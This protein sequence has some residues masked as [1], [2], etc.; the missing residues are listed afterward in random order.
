MNVELLSMTVPEVKQALAVLD[1]ATFRGHRVAPG[2][3]GPDIVLRSALE[4]RARGEEWFWCTPRLFYATDENLIV[5]SGDFKNSPRKGEV[6]IGLGV[7][8]S[9]EGRG[10]A[11]AGVALLVIE[12]F[13]RPEVS[14]V[15]AESAVWNIGSQRVLQKNGFV[16]RGERVDP[17]DGPLILWRRARG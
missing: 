6:E 14:A 7:A 10:Y 4:R 17:G 2:A 8:K 9:C 16:R 3:I 15:T 12:A 1:A 5:G 11:T 13:T